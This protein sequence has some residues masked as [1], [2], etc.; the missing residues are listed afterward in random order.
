[1]SK[2]T[3]RA[4]KADDGHL[5]LLESVDLPTNQEIFV[6]LDIPEDHVAR[7]QPKLPVRDLGPMKMPIDRDAIYADLI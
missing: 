5:K 7:G 1:M 6:T 2:R 3:V 4:I